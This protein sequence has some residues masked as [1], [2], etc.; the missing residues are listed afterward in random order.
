MRSVA[1]DCHH[2]PLL[3][4]FAAVALVKLRSRRPVTRA[5][6][7]NAS[8]SP[9]PDIPAK[10]KVIVIAGPT[11][12]GKTSLSLAL[13]KQLGGEIISADS[14]QVYQGMDV[15]SAK[16]PLAERE[17]I[18]H[19][20]I[21]VLP[22]TADF[23]AGDFFN[24]ARAATADVLSRGKVPI[25]V[26]GTGFY[27]RWYVQGKPATP[28]SS[29]AVTAA[30]AAALD[31]AMASVDPILAADPESDALWQAA[32]GVLAAAG[33]PGTASR[34]SRNDM[35][36]LRRALEIVMETG[37]PV[38]SFTQDG[39]V[40]DMML[41]PATQ[42]DGT[43]GSSMAT[44][45]ST[46]G[47]SMHGPQVPDGQ[48]PLNSHGASPIRVGGEVKGEVMG[49]AVRRQDD[50]GEDDQPSSKKGRF[51]PP[52]NTRPMHNRSVTA[53][54]DVAAEGG[55]NFDMAWSSGG[56]NHGHGAGLTVTGASERM[57]DGDV[58]AFLPSSSL[59]YDFRCFFLSHPSRI[60]LYQ[61]IDLRCERMVAGGWHMWPAA[62]GRTDVSPGHARGFVL[63]DKI[64]RVPSGTR[65]SGAAG[66]RRHARFTTGLDGLHS[67]DDGRV[68]A[69]RQTPAQ[70]VSERASFP[71][72][73]DG[74][75]QGGCGCRDYSRV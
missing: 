9:P 61:Q 35:Y 40:L 53:S 26:G 64:H 13:A 70:L 29:P 24:L 69:T 48:Q 38:G 7:Q 28:R 43:A 15:G 51:Q 16:L 58:P 30:A 56:G 12:V 63:C 60:H 44:V 59:D 11:A 73:A 45:S 5:M 52:V 54:A 1:I 14:V 46:G 21:D 66:R 62:R 2:S 71:V 20:L 68:T 32:V 22:P 31:A 49:G 41:S 18:P 19:H 6:Q 37:K 39:Q 4:K 36:R 10:Q 25:V 8:A 34:L 33:D 74:P 17:G 23:S 75:P 3:R 27:L 65:V 42:G 55:S 57:A 47:A 50:Q 67:Q 72:V